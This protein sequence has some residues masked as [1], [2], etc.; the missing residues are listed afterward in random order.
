MDSVAIDTPAV[1]LVR[2]R[3]VYRVVS[4]DKQAGRVAVATPRKT[5]NFMVLEEMTASGFEPRPGFVRKS[6]DGT[7]VRYEFLGSEKEPFE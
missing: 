7:R 2:G 3:L 4:V 6:I 5:L 1:F